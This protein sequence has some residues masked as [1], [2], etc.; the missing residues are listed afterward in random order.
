MS[1]APT[2][3]AETPISP[4]KENSK[5]PVSGGVGDETASEHTRADKGDHETSDGD[6]LVV[7]W[8]GLDDP[9]N[10]KKCVYIPS[11]S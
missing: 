11:Q 7:D 6:V 2:L 1:A 5:L 9:S 3:R 8:H 4:I 10:P